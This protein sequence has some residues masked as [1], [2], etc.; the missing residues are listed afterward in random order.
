MEPTFPVTVSAAA[1]DCIRGL[2]KT[3]EHQ[4]LGSSERGAQDI[5][6]KAFFAGYNFESLY[7]KEILPPFKPD[8]RNELDT[9]YIPS[10]YLDEQ[11]SDSFVKATDVGERASADAKFEQFTYNG[12]ESI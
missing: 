10:V 2:L 11:A 8:V 9:K 3:D 7:N 6:E 1:C 12:R 5:M 4:R